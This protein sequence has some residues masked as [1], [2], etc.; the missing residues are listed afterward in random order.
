MTT[1]GYTGHTTYLRWKVRIQQWVLLLCLFFFYTTAA[2]GI[3]PMLP[4]VYVEN[5]DVSGW[6]MSEK[7]DGVR[8]YW[9]G[10]K[11]LSKNGNILFPP[12]RFIQDLPSFPLEGELWAGRN[13]FEQTI[14]IVKQQHPHDGW[15]QL[16]FAIFDVP[17]APGG[18]SKRIEQARNW[19]AAHP[20]P[21]AFVITQ[22]P[23]RDQLHL[24]QELLRI[25][26]Q[27][28]EGLIVRK[29]HGLYEAGRSSGILKVKTF[30]DAEARVVAHLAG[31]GRNKGRLGSLLAEL[32]DGKRFKIGSGFSDADRED[33]PAIGECITF[34]YYGFYQS[35]IPKFPSFLRIRRDKSL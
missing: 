4:H 12:D 33:P 29:P 27:R 15:L 21:Y 31:T 17:R 9:D 20:S 25:E 8:G 10:E 13:S 26:E 22:I 1:A 34:K 35:G 28:G 7:L 5:T 2:N 24:H 18:F 6:L 3:E 11:L 16:K 23:V 19:F 14:S 32:A 30:Q